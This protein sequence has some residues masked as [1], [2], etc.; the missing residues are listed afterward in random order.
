MELINERKIAPLE[1]ASWLIYSEILQDFLW[2]VPDEAARERLFAE[3]VKEPVYTE[4]EIDLLR[5]ASK[6]TLKTVHAAKKAFPG[7]K[8]TPNGSQKG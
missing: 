4:A 8:V 6:E 2:A 1:D 5:G 3:G 7:S